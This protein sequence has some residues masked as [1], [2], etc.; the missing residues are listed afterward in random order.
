MSKRYRTYAETLDYYNADVLASAKWTKPLT[1]EWVEYVLVKP[2][3]LYET[4]LYVL[5]RREGVT[6][7]D[8]LEDV[9]RFDIWKSVRA[10]PIAMRSYSA[11]QREA[12]QHII[13]NIP[14]PV[15][16]RLVG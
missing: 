7:L 10:H 3:L 16:V 5:T 13:A 2:K 9:G 1:G 4:N 14:V 8:T 11:A 12:I 6:N 15:P